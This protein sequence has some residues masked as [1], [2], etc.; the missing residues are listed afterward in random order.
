MILR[1]GS[2]TFLIENAEFIPRAAMNMPH[3]WGIPYQYEVMLT[4]T[5]NQ[6]SQQQQQQQQRQQQS[7]T[8]MLQELFKQHHHP[9]DQQSNVGE[10]IDEPEI[11]MVAADKAVDLSLKKNSGKQNNSCLH[12]VPPIPPPVSR[13]KSVTLNNPAVIVS[14][15]EI[16]QN[17]AKISWN[18]SDD[19]D[20]N[21]NSCNNRRDAPTPASTSLK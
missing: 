19:F 14:I 2:P 12:L 3:Y 21:N 8:K 20:L 18:L 5:T 10:K 15:R 13:S 7:P 1:N 4:T 9:T 16:T 11:A 6:Q 17:T